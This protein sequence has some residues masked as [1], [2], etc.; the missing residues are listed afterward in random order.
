MTKTFVLTILA[1]L[2]TF[3]GLSSTVVAV[4]KPEIKDGII[5]FGGDIPSVGLNEIQSFPAADLPPRVAKIKG[6]V[7][8][9]QW[10]FRGRNRDAF[11]PIGFLIPASY[12]PDT[13][14]IS[15]V[16]VSSSVGKPGPLKFVLEGVFENESFALKITPPP[17]NP[18]APEYR[19]RIERLENNEMELSNSLGPRTWESLRPVADLPLP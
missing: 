1:A 12:D 18:T 9:G 6:K 2:L 8:G 15:F 3:F 17:I 5:T 11:G 14:K 13:K 10:Q 4:D 7:W 16:Y 19:L